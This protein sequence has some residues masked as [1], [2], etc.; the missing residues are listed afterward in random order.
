MTVVPQ[1]ARRS[2]AGPSHG[3][4]A[5][6]IGALIG[7]LLALGL[8]ASPIASADGGR[9]VRMRD[10]CEP[11]SFNA[12][13][14]PGTCVGSGDV[15]FDEFLDELNPKDGGHGA[16]DFTREVLGIKR[17]E[18]VRIVNIGGEVHSFTE[19]LN[20]GGGIVPLLDAALPPGTPPA[21]PANPATVDASF[22][23]AGQAMRLSGLSVGSHKFQCLIHPWMRTE[24]QVRSR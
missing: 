4:I 6:Q 9:E 16:W 10:K 14:G 24:I 19:V 15:T 17:G 12:A 21:I 8:L 1:V 5:R 23:P 7:L 18:T 11:N 22:L 13:V 2:A 3:R 20:Y